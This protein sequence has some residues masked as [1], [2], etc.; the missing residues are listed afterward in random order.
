LFAFTGS[1]ELL[2]R[3]QFQFVAIVSFKS[4]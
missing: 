2:G 1:R 3:F 4:L